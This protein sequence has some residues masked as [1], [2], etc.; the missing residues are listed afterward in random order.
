MEHCKLRHI[1][2]APQDPDRTPAATVP[3]TWLCTP[4]SARTTSKR[5]PPPGQLQPPAS[6]A[7]RARYRRLSNAAPL[8]PPGRTSTCRMTG[9]VD[10]A[11]SPSTP[12]FTG[13]SRQP[14]TRHPCACRQLSRTAPA[15]DSPSGA[16]SIPTPSASPPGKLIPVA[17]SRK[18]RGT[19][20]ITPTPS[21][22]APSAATA[23]RCASRANAVNAYC[24]MGDSA[25]APFV[26]TKPHTAGV[27]LKP[28]VQQRNGRAG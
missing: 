1:L 22:D 6:N 20:V 24:R 4:A 11:I 8:G 25:S 15:R 5:T 26:A 17:A 12:T 10:R 9:I 3:G 28:R 21:L 13:T 19:P 27:K 23:P 14:K 16:N 7:F 2:G 18:S